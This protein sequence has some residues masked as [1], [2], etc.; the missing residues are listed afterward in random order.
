MACTNNRLVVKIQSG[1]AR[2]FG[3]TIK[4]KTLTKQDDGTY[5]IPMDLSDYI[6]DLQIKLYPYES[7]EPVIH[8]I[9]TSEEDSLIGQILDQSGEDR[10]RFLVQINS[11]D[12]QI[13]VPEKEYVL[14]IYLVN[15][16]TRIMISGE[17][18]NIGVFKVCNS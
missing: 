15:G 2:S 12:M 10:G 14:A 13:L 7:V 1:E 18:D 8:K 17:G 5:Y 3:F 6:V 9:I 16:D 4:T 11:D